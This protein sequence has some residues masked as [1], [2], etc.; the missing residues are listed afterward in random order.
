MYSNCLLVVVATIIYGQKWRDTEVRRN[1]GVLGLSFPMFRRTPWRRNTTSAFSL[2]SF[3]FA[4][5]PS[6]LA[7]AAS[8]PSISLSLS[9]SSLYIF[10]F[11]ANPALQAFFSILPPGVL[12]PQTP[13]NPPEPPLSLSL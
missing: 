12:P 6:S 10:C 4:K 5:R 13:H 1:F 2:R 11:F 7:A 9:T 8:F 3:P